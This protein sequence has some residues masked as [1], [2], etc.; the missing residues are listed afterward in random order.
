[1]ITD[2][3]LSASDGTIARPFDRLPS[4]LAA[5]RAA[6]M[7]PLQSG[8]DGVVAAQ[9]PE[10]GTVTSGDASHPGQSTPTMLSWLA[11]AVIDG[12]AQCACSNHPVHPDLLAAANGEKPAAQPSREEDDGDAG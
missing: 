9:D 11:D 5:P 12:L 3:K 4:N 10:P 1:M 6:R 2:A 7:Q 8:P